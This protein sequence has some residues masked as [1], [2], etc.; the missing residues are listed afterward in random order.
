MTIVWILFAGWVLYFALR[1]YLQGIWVTLLGLFGFAVAYGASLLWAK[2]AGVAIQ[3]YGLGSTAA[4]MVA[5]VVIFILAYLLASTLPKLFLEKWLDKKTFIARLAG[6]GAGTVLGCFS[7]LVIV[8]GATFLSA[9]WQSRAGNTVPA[10]LAVPQPL[11]TAAGKLIGG[12]AQ[13]GSKAV[14]A[15]EIHSQL[16]GALLANPEQFVEGFSSL[17][18]SG[19]MEQFFNDGTA[20]YYMARKDYASLQQTPAFKNIAQQEGV[21][22]ISK[23]ALAGKDGDP[24]KVQQSEIYE[25]LAHNMTFV[26]R[27]MEY[28]KTNPEVQQILNDPEVIKLVQDKNPLN[29]MFNAKVSRLVDLIM[30]EDSA[31]ESHDFTQLKPGNPLGGLGE[32]KPEASRTVKPVE[33]YKWVDDNG[34]MQ[35]TD[36]DNTPEHKRA[37]AE[38]MTAQGE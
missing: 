15:K 14:G 11:A 31:M 6:L 29:I 5:S 21:Q 25:T 36:Y 9:A 24:T 37:N 38:L 16:M 10:Q 3:G 20:Q 27:R 19:V 32:I 35:Y 4:M 28:L 26:W 2:D 12:V 18:D 22:S 23:L 1:G 8:W 34:N 17:S 13:A 33:I 7:G 30:Q